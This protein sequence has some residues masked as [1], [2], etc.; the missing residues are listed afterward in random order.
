MQP[1]FG[2]FDQ[3][4]VS[5]QTPWIMEEETQMI[6]KPAITVLDKGDYVK[7][8]LNVIEMWILNYLSDKVA[9]FA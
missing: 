6:I 2:S 5:S 7:L 8:Q 4:F 1:Q 3:Q 9:K